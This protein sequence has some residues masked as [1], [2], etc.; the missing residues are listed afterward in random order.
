MLRAAIK[1]TFFGGSALYAVDP[2]FRRQFVNYEV[3]EISKKVGNAFDIPKL[4]S[5]VDAVCTKADKFCEDNIT[6][7]R[8]K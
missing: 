5:T 6:Q 7:I 4:G 8:P 3:R 1:V 2:K